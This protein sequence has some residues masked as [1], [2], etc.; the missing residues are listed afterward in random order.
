MLCGYFPASSSLAQTEGGFGE[1]HPLCGRVR[2]KLDPAV[3]QGLGPERGLLC[4]HLAPKLGSATVTPGH[5]EPANPVHGT[6][7][8]GKINLGVCPHRP[9]RLSVQRGQQRP[10]CGQ[11][12]FDCPHPFKNRSQL[13]QPQRDADKGPG[14]LCSSRQVKKTYEKIA[15]HL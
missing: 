15:E 1:V 3:W 8:Q 2:T 7:C 4:A 9:Q 11:A 14:T 12:A 6:Q 5:F 13:P 10:E